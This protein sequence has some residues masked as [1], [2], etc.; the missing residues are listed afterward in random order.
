MN[1]Q[2]VGETLELAVRNTHERYANFQGVVVFG[3]FASGKENPS[4]LDLI[5]ILR[6]YGSSWDFSPESE[7]DGMDY[8]PDHFTYLEIEDFF[9]SH[10]QHLADGNVLKK[11]EGKGL[12][13][14]ESLI[15]MDDLEQARRWLD[16]YQARAENFIGTE[17]ARNLLLRL[18]ENEVRA[19]SLG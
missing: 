6:Q 14:I 17:E 9:L 12:I 10:F 11:R 18:Y 7:G 15:A 13:H 2:A 16:H 3:S 19:E 8:H 1:K 5:P 4:D